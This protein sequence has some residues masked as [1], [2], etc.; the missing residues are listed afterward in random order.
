MYIVSKNIAKGEKQQ[1][2][3]VELFLFDLICKYS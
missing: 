3:S 2:D 1:N